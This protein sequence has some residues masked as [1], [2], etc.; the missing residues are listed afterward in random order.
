MILTPANGF[1]IHVGPI[2]PR[3]ALSKPSQRATTAAP[4]VEHLLTFGHIPSDAADGSAQVIRTSLADAGRSDEI[5]NSLA[6]T[7]SQTTPRALPPRVSDE[8]E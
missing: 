1:R 3:R 4:E 6:P 2:K 7:A 8:S 5:A